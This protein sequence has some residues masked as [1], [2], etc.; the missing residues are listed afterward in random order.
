MAVPIPVHQPA[1][2]ILN[3]TFTEKDQ[4]LAAPTRRLTDMLLDDLEVCRTDWSG[5]ASNAVRAAQFSLRITSLDRADPPGYTDGSY[6]RS[7]E[8]NGNSRDRFNIS[9]TPSMPTIPVYCEVNGWD[10]ADSPIYWRLQC[11]HVLCRHKNFHHYRYGGVCEVLDVEWQGRSRLAEF[12]LFD[13]VSDTSLDYDYNTNTPDTVVMGGHA[14]LSV[15]ALPPGCAAIL[16]DYAHLRIGGT[17]PSKD[18]VIAYIQRSVG[19]R[20]PNMPHIVNACFAHESG[21]KQ[22]KTVAQRSAKWTLKQAQHHNPPQPDCPVLFD[23]PDDPAHFPLVSFDWGVGASQYTKIGDRV[24]GAGPTWDWRQNVRTGINELLQA[25]NDFY[26]SNLTWKQWAHGGWHDYN[27]SGAQADQYANTVAGSAEGQLVSG[28]L[29]PI[30]I[31]VNALTAPLPD[32]PNLGPP[33]DW[34]PL[35]PLGDYPEPKTSEQMA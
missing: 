31:D 27:G 6:P 25:L 1:H 11:R 13:P 22:F 26:K 23:W 32:P 10:P 9:R 17:N 20:N 28:D 3:N 4:G 5:T 21:M 16:K 14:I 12:K 2:H 15:A 7:D 29:M 19:S 34:P 8:F 35:L 33:P 24:I 30:G 18:D